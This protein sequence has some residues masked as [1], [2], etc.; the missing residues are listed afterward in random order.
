MDSEVYPDNRSGAGMKEIVLFLLVGVMASMAS[1]RQ[2][3]YPV[4]DSAAFV[5]AWAESV[6]SLTLAHGSRGT[7]KGVEVVRHCH[8]RSQFT[9]Q[10]WE[11]FT[12]L[13]R[14][15]GQ[16]HSRRLEAFRADTT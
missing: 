14:L 8:G 6:P 2:W 3:A 9:D 5:E 11:R 15:R 13:L 16:T 12:R 1:A 4:A 7:I 10:Q